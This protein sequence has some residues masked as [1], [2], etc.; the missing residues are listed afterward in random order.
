VKL[1]ELEDLDGS[2]FR[3]RE[4][5]GRVR[6]VIVRVSRQDDTLNVWGKGVACVFWPWIPR[7]KLDSVRLGPG[8]IIRDAHPWTTSLSKFASGARALALQSNLC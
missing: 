5:R 1:V 3:D 8:L 2:Y 7:H 6:D 4:V